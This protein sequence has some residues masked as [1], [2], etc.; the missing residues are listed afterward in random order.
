M[1]LTIIGP[2][3][4]SLVFGLVVAGVAQLIAGPWTTRAWLAQA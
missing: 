4:I 3:L 2:V 1:E